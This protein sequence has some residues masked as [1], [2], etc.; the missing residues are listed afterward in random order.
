ML[1]GFAVL[2]CALVSLTARSLAFGAGESVLWSFGNG[3]DGVSPSAGLTMDATGNLYGTTS[4][5]GA[6]GYGTVFKLTT[7]AGGIWSE[8]ILWSF[9]R[10]GDG[11]NPLAA[12]VMDATGHLYGTTSTGGTYGKGA[13]FKLTPTAGGIWTESILWNFGGGT[14]GVNPAGG[15]IMDARGNLY[16]M[17]GAGGADNGGTV[18]ELTRPSTDEGNWTESIL[19]SFSGGFLEVDDTSDSLTIDFHGDLYGTTIFGGVYGY[20][21]AFELI[22]P[23]TTGGNWTESV[24]WNF[25]N[26]VDAADPEGG[27]IMDATGHLYGNSLGGGVGAGTVFELTP[28]S[29][30]EGNWTESIL[31]NF[32]SGSYCGDGSLP[33]AGLIM[34]ASGNLYGTTVLGGVYGQPHG[35]NGTVFKL[36]PPATAGESWN[37]SVVWSFDGADGADP[38]AGVIMDASGNLY[39]TTS[40]GGPYDNYNILTGGMDLGGTAFKISATQLLGA[41]IVVKPTTNI[42]FPNAVI[43]STSN[44]KL[45]V[46]NTGPSQLLGSVVIISGKPPTTRFGIT[47]PGSFA[48]APMT[49]TTIT[50]TFT[51]TSTTPSGEGATVISNSVS[52]SSIK[53]NLQGRGIAPPP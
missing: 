10:D 22:P 1:T 30:D 35:A 38:E 31:W 7:T 51:P 6:Y 13:V 36:T 39:G 4:T 50:L 17:T 32:C 12:L 52:D 29:T 42:V 20:G 43:G 3:S 49:A 5:G 48:L 25:G 11:M 45:L 14:D 28:P 37:E 53:L 8:S 19:W 41:Q 16:G 24:L 47:G 27:V 23:S 2:T 18:F 33:E 34:D 9:G 21:T 44:F 46:Q 26:G 40:A 15:M